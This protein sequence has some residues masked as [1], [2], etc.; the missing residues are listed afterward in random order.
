MKRSASCKSRAW[1]FERCPDRT[2]CSD[3]VF[4][5]LWKQTIVLL[6]LSQTVTN[7]TDVFFSGK[8]SIFPRLFSLYCSR[9]ASCFY[10]RHRD[11]RAELEDRHRREIAQLKLTLSAA[12][13]PG[14][15]GAA[16]CSPSSALPTSSDVRSPAMTG[17]SLAH[18]L[19]PIGIVPGAS[20]MSPNQLSPVLNDPAI[21]A[22]LAG[23]QTPVQVC[24]LPFVC[25]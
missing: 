3:P 15:G 19:P 18:L 1:N 13:S 12:T 22:A 16:V 24:V 11:Q 23:I 7:L 17:S 8:R 5:T 20:S 9:F 10:I 6:P 4:P 2:P 21:A 25:N 14:S